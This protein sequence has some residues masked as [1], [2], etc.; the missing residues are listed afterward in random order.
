MQQ[1]TTFKQRLRNPKF[2]TL[3]FGGIFSI[4]CLIAIASSVFLTRRSQDTRQQA[5]TDLGVVTVTYSTEPATLV[6]NQPASV[7]FF[8]NTNSMQVDGVQVEFTITTDVANDFNFVAATGSNLQLLLKKVTPVSGGYKV[9]AIATAPVGESF[10]SSTNVHF[11]SLTFTPT[12]AGSLKLAFDNDQS[13]STQ[14]KSNPVKD[15]LK[16]ITSVTYQVGSEVVTSPAATPTQAATP[17]AAALTCNSTCRTAAQCQAINP[18]W[19][20]LYIN[21]CTGITCPIGNCRL[22]SNP[23]NTQCSSAT[24]TPKTVVSP[25]PTATA[26][27]ILVCNSTCRTDAQCKAFNANWTCK[28]QNNC[29]G[30]TCPIGNC[31]LATNPDNAQCTTATPT[32]KSTATPTSGT[33]G[34]IT[35]PSTSPTTATSPTATPT[36]TTAGTNATH[37]PTPTASSN[38]QD[39]EQE[40]EQDNEYEEENVALPA[41]GQSNTTFVVVATVSAVV[42][43]GILAVLF[44]I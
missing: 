31:R 38:S 32:P 9:Q 2:R 23:S 27:P 40:G 3:L 42:I 7:K 19:T 14:H 30:F 1:K 25:S 16:P 17:T 6:P 35:T 41:A 24:P 15:Q 12:K 33:G 43:L 8:I 36:S 34:P 18:N 11:G 13:L 22:A 10:S 21:N 20:C 26:T 29:V 44:F 5:A 28:L 37:T 39:D 4:I